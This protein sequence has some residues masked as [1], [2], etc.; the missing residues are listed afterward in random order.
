MIKGI[1]MFEAHGEYDLEI[2]GSILVS[3][4]KGAWNIQTAQAYIFSR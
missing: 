2:I 3:N 1:Y 4:I